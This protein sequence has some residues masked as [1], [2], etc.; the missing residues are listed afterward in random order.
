MPAL[1]NHADERS[2]LCS[3]GTWLRT[4]FFGEQQKIEKRDDAEQDVLGA[5]DVA[6]Q[7][8][9]RHV[10]EEQDRKSVR[11][12]QEQGERQGHGQAILCGS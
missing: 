5:L 3:I 11:Q 10:G 6:D 7:H 1:L 2:G 4:V 8:F 9:G 12:E